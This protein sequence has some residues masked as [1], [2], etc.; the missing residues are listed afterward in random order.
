MLLV[1]FRV[2]STDFLAASMAR[3]RLPGAKATSAL[4]DSCRVRRHL[5]LV[6]PTK[7]AI[8]LAVSLLLEKK[9]ECP[10]HGDRIV[11]SIS[12]AS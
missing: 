11:F 4:A 6:Q 8:G 3:S 7:Q 1:A 5:L 2:E 10:L 9:L 12:T